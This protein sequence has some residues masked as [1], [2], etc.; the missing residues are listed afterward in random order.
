MM[1]KQSQYVISRSR[2]AYVVGNS[3]TK[4]GSSF[5]LSQRLDEPI[6]SPPSH[7]GS[8]SPYQTMSDPIHI[9]DI[10]RSRS[11]LDLWRGFEKRTVERSGSSGLEGFSSPQSSV[12]DTL[13]TNSPRSPVAT[14]SHPKVDT[15]AGLAA[16]ASQR[17]IRTD[18]LQACRPPSMSPKGSDAVSNRLNAQSLES[19]SL[20]S[21]GRMDD[22]L[23]TETSMARSGGNSL[24]SSCSITAE[25][26]RQ[27]SYPSIT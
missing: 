12:M 14:N 24:N 13:P 20:H 8:H 6:T 15:S 17:D 11:T 18:W 25:G 3:Q 21:S 2:T 4:V 22:Y 5:E 9:F 1:V 16:E 19:L 23:S 27:V 26:R 7:A 10:R